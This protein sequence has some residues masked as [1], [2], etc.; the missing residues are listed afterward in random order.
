MP[1][2]TV[3]H[4]VLENGSTMPDRPAY[5]V[6]KGGAWQP[7]SWSAYADEVRGAA[8]SLIAL[9]GP[10]RVVR[11]YSTET[12]QLIHELRKHT[13]WI[14]SIEFSPDD[15][16]LATGDRNGGLFVWEAWTGREYLTLKAHSKGVTG[17]S[18]RSD[19]NVLASCSEDGSLRVWEVENGKQIKNWSAHG[20]GAT[21]IEFCRDGRILSCGRDR[22]AKLWKQDGGQIRAFE[23]FGDLAV[24]VTFCDETNHVI[25]GDWTG[26]IRVFNAEDGTRLGTLTSNPPTL[27]ERLAAANKDLA[28]KQAEQQQ[29][30][31]AAQKAVDAAKKAQADLALA[32]K[33]VD[34]W[35]A[36]ITFAQRLKELKEQRAAALEQLASR[37]L[38]YERL[39][40]EVQEAQ[41]ALAQAQ[42]NLVEAQ[43]S[44]SVAQGQVDQVN[45]E[46]D[47]VRALKPP[48]AVAQKN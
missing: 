17:V 7:T 15:V 40:A 34:R 28:S 2:L 47:I 30:A 18:W 39:A 42:Q 13:D 9:G 5:Y 1:A 43:N 10:Q 12:G 16:L 45:N 24:R 35:K 46:I 33:N 22:V 38:E 25:A 8:K 32:Q 36:E 41:A 37:Q 44:L 31:E 29:L 3:A 20:G 4:K 27:A 48:D 6:K 26:E 21:S 23:A 19:S 14:Y 11:I